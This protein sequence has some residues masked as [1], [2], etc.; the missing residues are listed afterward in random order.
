MAVFC[1]FLSGAFRD[2]WFM[3]LE[4]CFEE[5]GFGVLFEVVFFFAGL[6]LRGVFNHGL[7]VF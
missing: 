2:S 1:F 5:V 4:S 7:A 6:G 3:G